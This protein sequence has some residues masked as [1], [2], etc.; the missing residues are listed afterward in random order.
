MNYLLIKGDYMTENE[1]VA[2]MVRLRERGL[3]YTEIGAVYGITKQRVYQ[4]IGK[5]YRGDL[6]E[7]KR[8]Y[9]RAY[10]RK[11]QLSINGF[12]GLAGLVK[13][14]TMHN[15]FYRFLIGQDMRFTVNDFNKICKATGLT[16]TQL[17]EIEK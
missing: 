11:T 1:K 7:I 3:T 16:L 8:P 5:R 17:S 12:L 4:I 10:F 13:T 14:K 6:S 15:N 9:L 2:E